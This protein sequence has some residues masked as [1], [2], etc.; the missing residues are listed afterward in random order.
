MRNSFVLGIA[1]TRRRTVVFAVLLLF[2]IASSLLGTSLIGAEDDGS[3]QGGSSRGVCQAWPWDCGDFTC[4]S[5]YYAENGICLLK[6]GY[7]KNDFWNDRIKMHDCSTY[8]W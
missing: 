3:G 5:G 7:C 6:S 2:A 1:A 4:P 8:V